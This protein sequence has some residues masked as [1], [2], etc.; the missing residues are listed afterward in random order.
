MSGQRGNEDEILEAS[1]GNTSCNTASGH[2]YRM[3]ANCKS[4]GDDEDVPEV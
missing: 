2:R 3:D 1:F 4:E